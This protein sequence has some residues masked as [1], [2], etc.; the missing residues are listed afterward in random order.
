MGDLDD[1]FQVSAAELL[2]RKDILAVPG[3]GFMVSE[4]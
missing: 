2:D 3:G 4:G 1:V